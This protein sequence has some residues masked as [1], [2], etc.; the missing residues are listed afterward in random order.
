VTTVRVLLVEDDPLDAHLIQS[1]LRRENRL[2]VEHVP[3]AVEALARLTRGAADFDAVLS[4]IC[5][6]HMSGIELVR[7]LRR[8][9][10]AIP[11]FLMT[12]HADIATA[13]DGMRA[14]AADFLVKPLDPDAAFAMI[15]RE[16][17]GNIRGLPGPVTEDE[18]LI[19]GSH[20]RLEA[21]R[22][23]AR[24]VATLSDTR[25]LITGESGT[26]KNLLAQTIHRLSGARGPFVEVNCAAL[27]TGLL[28]SELFGHERGAFTDART[29]KHGL[30]ETAR[31]GSILLNE[32]G[33]MPL[34]LQPKLLWFLENQ[35]FRRVGGTGTLTT[36]TRVMA[37]TN[38]DL[39]AAVRDGRFRGDLLWRLDVVSIRMPSLRAMPSVISE[40]AAR[41]LRD[42]CRRLGRGVPGISA[43]SFAALERHA[44]PGNMRQLWNV[45][46]RA[47]VFHEAGELVLHP[48]VDPEPAGLDR[49]QIPRGVSLEE[50]ER[51][52]LEAELATRQGDLAA[53]A[54]S[55]G[56]SRKTLWEKRRRHGL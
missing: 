31:N 15:D 30:F 46:E 29:L 8:R 18:S 12:A 53:V 4:D 24:K 2:R 39:E 51:Y 21:V 5:L 55:L 41:F 23:F 26:G 47:V 50:L 27:P 34:E 11:L 19:V 22:E 3:S 7:Q 44:W 16:A 45:V 6:P 32:I 13:V 35:E 25:I 33:S 37:A 17:R 54:A 28:E 36:K 20:P 48:P 56:I 42:I 38:T 43:D 10:I 49:H 1:G 40:L 9:G 14:G 52:Y